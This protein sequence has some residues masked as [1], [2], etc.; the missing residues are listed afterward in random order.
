MLASAVIRQMVTVHDAVG[1]SGL[2]PGRPIAKI[3]MEFLVPQPRSSLPGSASAHQDRFAYQQYT[4]KRPILSFLGRK[5]YVYA[6]DGSLILFLKHPLMKLRGEFTMYTDESETT[7]LLV[8][9]ARSVLALNMA[10]D[11]F[12]AVTGE[13]T[14]SIRSRGMKSLIR[15]TWDILDANDQVVGLMEETGFAM[16]RRFIKFLPGQHKI[17]L[18]GQLVAT[19]K[20]TFRFFSK[21]EVLDLSPGGNRI[22][23]RFGIACA[24]LALMKESAREASD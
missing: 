10:H 23:H 4:I 3:I 5:Y 2:D 7:P 21:E 12:D 20:Q 8:V 17:E 24:L 1:A 16:L 13:K 15:D 19:L 6:P 22:D 11:V 14:G 18:Q 9:R